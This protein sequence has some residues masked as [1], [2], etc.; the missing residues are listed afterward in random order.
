MAAMVS[1]T[2]DSPAIITANHSGGCGSATGTPAGGA[3]NRTPQ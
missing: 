3:L 1:A 2:A